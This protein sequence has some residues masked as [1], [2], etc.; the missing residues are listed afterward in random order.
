M[1]TNVINFDND[2]YFVRY[3]YLQS[4]RIFEEITKDIPLLDKINNSQIPQTN[5]P[6]A[7]Q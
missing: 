5:N 2:N 6:F 7:I 4:K 3:P 1:D